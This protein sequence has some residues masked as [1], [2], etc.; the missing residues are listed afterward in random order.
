M[1]ESVVKV[2]SEILKNVEDFIKERKYEFTSKKHVVNLAI[3]E[4][5]KSKGFNKDIKKR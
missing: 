4:F 2:D 5:L 3:I 1:A